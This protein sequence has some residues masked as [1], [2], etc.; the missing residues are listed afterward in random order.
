MQIFIK[1]LRNLKRSFSY[2]I[3]HSIFSMFSLRE[4]LA[5]QKYVNQKKEIHNLL[6]N[7]IE[8]SGV[9]DT[10]FQ[11]LIDL[12]NT[13]N[14]EENREELEHFLRLISKIA[15]NHHRDTDF[16][17][18][19][20]K[21]LLHLENVIKQTFSISE[22]FK[23]FKSNKL[24][25]LSLIKSKIIALDEEI[26]KLILEEKNNYCHFFFP[27]I[28]SLMGEEKVKQIESEISNID[29][30]EEKRQIGENDSVI[31]SLIRNDSLD[32]FISHVTNSNLSIESEIQP[33]FFET[34]SFLLKQKKTTLIEYAAFFG[35]IQIFQYLLL[36]KV[37]PTASLMQ[38]A[39]HSKN[40]ELIH[41]LEEKV[42][43]NPNECFVE[44][45]KCHHNDIATYIKDNFLESVKECVDIIIGDTIKT[46]IPIAFIYYNFEFFPLELDSIEY[47]FSF[48]YKY[49]YIEFLKRYLGKYN[50]DMNKFLINIDD[51]EILEDMNDF[52]YRYGYNNYLV[53]N[54]HTSQICLMQ[55]LECGYEYGAEYFEKS[56][57]FNYPCIL[58]SKG[59]SPID[60]KHEKN[61][62]ILYECRPKCDL[63]QFIRHKNS[64]IDVIH[65]E[66]I[67]TYDYIL[68][69]GIA[70]GI[71]FLSK[72][73]SLDFFIRSYE[74][75]IDENYY[76][77]IK[78]KYSSTV[79]LQDN[80]LK[81]ENILAIDSQSEIP[82]ESLHLV[83]SS[84]IYTY[85]ILVYSIIVKR[86]KFEKKIDIIGYYTS[87]KSGNRPDV[88]LIGNKYIVGFLQKCWALNPDDRLSY[89]EIID[90]VTNR[91]F[92][93]YFQSFD[94]KAVL[95]YLNIYGSEYDY[96]KMKFT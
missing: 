82:P 54:K 19:T 84:M 72:R 71:R 90:Y 2:H 95:K 45:I 70:I 15:K 12:I 79:F 47:P 69:L 66:T 92:Y 50:I 62:S 43:I 14:Y 89:D 58:K 59:F 8:N 94:R 65:S 48:M 68:I 37:E 49:K 32:D 73:N 10:D 77:F 6:L 60:F 7:F 20:E 96:I 64:F 86:I 33:S 40:G 78:G 18:K 46:K 93:S 30:F 27:E 51:Y 24:I 4:A 76:P 91:E 21:I 80:C 81:N 26:V 85:S 42:K 35:S 13:Q 25:I 11:N 31:C 17:K 74:I 22:I 3:S 83:P 38:Y 16:F 88:S 34:N 67:D 53:K 55:V 29:N 41:L 44:S 56:I 23:I 57:Q 5:I 75:I 61:P 63:Y 36:N 28:K 87:L 39:I 1:I 9:N 52:I